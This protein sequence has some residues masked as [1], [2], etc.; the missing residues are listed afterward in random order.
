M[1][2]KNMGAKKVMIVTDKTVAKLDAMRY[3]LE[4]LDSEGIEYIVWD[5]CRVE[6]KDTSIKEAVAFSKQHRPDA[7]LAVG[8]GSV[9]DTAKLMNLYTAFPGASDM[10]CLI[11]TSANKLHRR[12]LFGLR[13]CTSWY[14]LAS[15][16]FSV[17]LIFFRQ[18]TT[19]H[20]GAS[21]LDCRSNH[22]WHGF[23]DD[24]HCDLRPCVK[25]SQDRD[26]S[27]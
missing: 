20:Q 4:A 10:C 17:N 11:M 22:S 2:F 27:P 24:R 21:P 18:R 5:Q 25:A 12:G 1:D 3:S 15:S 6:P 19:N 14:G 9:M 16:S 26:R 23:R 7:F 8:G 13:E